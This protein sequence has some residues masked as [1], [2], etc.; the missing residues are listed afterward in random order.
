MSTILI[1]NA[2]LINEGSLEIQDVFIVDQ[3][4]QEIGIN[5]NHKADQIIDAS[6]KHLIP[7]V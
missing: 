1:K 5:L 4:I 2:T 6:G 7:G 3:F